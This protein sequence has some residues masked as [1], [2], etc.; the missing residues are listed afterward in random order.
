MEIFPDA[1]GPVTLDLQSV[2]GSGRICNSF[3]NSWL[4][5]LAVKM[6][7]GSK[8]KALEWPQ[9]YMLIFQMLKGR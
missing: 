7:I 8:L 5:S 1:Q 9:D 6:K 2:I 3:D 4:S